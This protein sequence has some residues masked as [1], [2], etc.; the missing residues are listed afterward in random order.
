MAD[1]ANGCR[2]VQEYAT[3]SMTV[4]ENCARQPRARRSTDTATSW[5]IDPARPERPGSS[6][7]STSTAPNP[8]QLD[9]RRASTSGPSTRATR[10]APAAEWTKAFDL[11]AGHS[12]T[13]VAMDKGVGYVGLVRPVQQRR[14][15][16]VVW[17]PTPR[18]PGRRSPC[19]ANVPNRYIGGVGIDPADTPARVPRRERLQPSVHRGPG[20]RGR[21]RL[22]DPG[23]R[24]DLDRHLGEPARTCRP[25]RSRR[26]R[27][28]RSCSA[29]TSVSS[30]GR[31]VRPAGR[32]SAPT[33]PLTTVM[34]VE[35]AG[36]GNVYAA[37][38][39]RGI[40]SI[41]LP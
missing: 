16:P 22:R 5:K 32:S 20:R 23:R 7:R 14:V 27:R 33:C 12:A 28:V 2:Q 40:W 26:P 30:T 6:R 8:D 41:P 17:P 29:P 19:P 15:Q 34:D 35:L 38:H 9:R 10:S 3:L 36:D 24:P 4:T 11:G 37:T 39:G 25:A 1:P 21:P 31:R 18:A 13:A